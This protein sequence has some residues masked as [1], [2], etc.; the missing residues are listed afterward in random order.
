MIEQ[1]KKEFIN[2]FG[3]CGEIRA[4]F[5]PGRVNLI[6]EHTDYNGGH[7]FPCALSVGTFAIA[8]KRNDNLVKAYSKNFESL[9]TIEFTLSE[10]VYEEKHDWANY[11]KGVIKIFKD[12]QFSINEGFDVFF[13]GNIPNGAGLSSSASIELATSVILK[14]LF[15]LNVTMVDMVKMSQQ[16]EN[17]FIGVNCGIMDQFAI[18]MGKKEKAILL[19]CNT[20]SYKYSPVELGDAVLIIANTNKRRGLAESKYNERREECERALKQLQQE[21]D[22]P[23][24]GAMSPE[25]FESYKHLISSQVDVKRAKHAVY[26]NARTLEAVNKL[27]NGDIRGFGQLMNDSHISLKDDYEVTGFELDTLVAAAWEEAGVIGSRMTGAGFG[28]CTVSVVKAE[29]VDTFIAN[30][31]EKYTGK[32]GLKADFYVVNIGDGAG[33]LTGMLQNHR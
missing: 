12:H 3:N 18:G 29:K 4:F 5:A 26:E 20:L 11:V 15:N 16:A 17:Q 7:V 23:S 6:G 22:I 28:G 2:L 21:L 1:L 10:L 19:D 14:G 25:L 30:V 27:Q 9:K 31:G 8:R 33:E 24:L 13:Y 32:T